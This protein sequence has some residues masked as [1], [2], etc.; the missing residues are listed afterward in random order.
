MSIYNSMKMEIRSGLRFSLLALCT[1]LFM[2]SGTLYGE[3]ECCNDN[4]E[5]GPVYENGYYP[6]C[7]RMGTAFVRADFLYLR[8]CQG[9]ISNANN[10]TQVAQPCICTPITTLHKSQSDSIDSLQPLE[11]KNKSPSFSWNPG[12]RIVVGCDFRDCP[13]EIVGSWTNYRTKSQ[14]C[15]RTKLLALISDSD[16]DS[17]VSSD[18]IT[19]TDTNPTTK[20][21][22][23]LNYADLLLGFRIDF[24]SS[25]SFK[26]FLGVRAAEF[27]QKLCAR[28]IDDL[29][30]PTDCCN[31]CDIPITPIIPSITK[32]ALL[33][34]H[35]R[36][37]Q[38]F[39][40]V[41]PLLG[42]AAQWNL[43][44]GFGLYLCADVGNLFGNYRVQ[45]R[46]RN[47]FDINNQTLF[48]RRYRQQNCQFF[49]DAYIGVS[50]TICL[51][52]DL[53][54]TFALGLEQHTFFNHNNINGCGDLNLQG[55]T[56]SA[57]LE[58]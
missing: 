39:D 53:L 3:D 4:Q 1:A 44:C 20:W 55:C 50:S 47:S 18:T 43:G 17:D 8:A 32:K 14:K 45:T 16:S 42:F 28:R 48:A 10:C 35:Q 46:V 41:G 52:G 7:C 6:I 19:T 23:N 51:C 33:T 21:H 2:I 58:Y 30:T 26:T 22:L 24:C 11:L 34:S 15:P 40:G 54:M 25:V 37:K 31:C 49:F 5:G 57:G 38:H 56:F 29:G 13:W 12:Y 9:G 36:S 27:N